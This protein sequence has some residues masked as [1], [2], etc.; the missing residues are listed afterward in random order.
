MVIPG[1]RYLVSGGTTGQVFTKVSGEDGDYQWSTPS[2]GGTPGG[3]DTQIQFNN[4]GAFGGSASMTFDPVGVSATYPLF[5]FT[6][7]SGYCRF[8]TDELR[9]AS[10]SGTTSN[11]TLQCTGTGGAAIYIDGSNGSGVLIY[12][13]D[14]NGSY[15]GTGWLVDD[16]DSKFDLQSLG[17]VR[18]GDTQTFSNGTLFIVDVPNSKTT[19]NV[20]HEMSNGSGTVTIQL[21]A[22]T[23]TWTFTLPVDDGDSG[24]VLTTDG[25]G[26]TSWVAPSGGSGLT[27]P[28]VL[29]RSLG[30]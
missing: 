16:P 8:V 18:I 12:G 22:A 13:A 25:S 27:S 15:N 26:N 14:Y 10:I 6:D 30:S 11:I 19:S 29:S 3:S 1:W 9:V 21:D 4:A 24:D 23:G 28:Q 5:T 7:G 20:K 17:T 2:S